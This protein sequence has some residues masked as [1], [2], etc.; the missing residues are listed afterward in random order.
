MGFND[1]TLIVAGELGVH[2]GDCFYITEDSACTMSK[3]SPAINQS[4][5]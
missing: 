4:F 2:L 1:D 5:G 3:Q